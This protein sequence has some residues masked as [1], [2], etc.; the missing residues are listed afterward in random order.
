MTFF[1]KKFKNRAEGTKNHANSTSKSIKRYALNCV[2]VVKHK[3]AL[4]RT[5]YRF[6]E[7]CNVLKLTPNELLAVN[8]DY[9]LSFN[10]VER[11]Y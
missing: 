10:D 8:N 5:F 6:I 4:I 2:G 9:T 11:G 3:N 7:I 1:Q